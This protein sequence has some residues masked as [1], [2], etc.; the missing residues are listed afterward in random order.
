MPRT[1]RNP[2]PPRVARLVERRKALGLTQEGLARLAGFSTSLM[3]KIERGAVDL[4]S[5]SAQH[6]VGLA[7]ALGLPLNALLDEDLP[8]GEL[9]K[10]LL[11]PVYRAPEDL[12]REDVERFAITPEQVPP[13][14]EVSRLAYLTLPGRWFTTLDV[15]FPLTR[16]VHV[17]TEL[18]PLVRPGGVYVVRHGEGMGF[19]T[20]EALRGGRLALY[21]LDPSLPTLW[22][23]GER[24]EVVG[25]VR[26][27]LTWE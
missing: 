21:P 26:A 14:A 6:V 5:L 1:P 11:L 9:A 19:A 16:R 2:L 20:D 10:P 27:W 18:R 25:L 15:P 4:R 24:P 17:M 3:A 23:E 22:L 7:K 13:G 12:A 8:G